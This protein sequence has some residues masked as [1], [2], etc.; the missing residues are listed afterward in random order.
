M[1]LAPGTASALDADAVAAGRDVGAT[2]A[3]DRDIGGRQLNFQRDGEGFRDAETGSHW[4]VPGRATSGPLAGRQLTAVPLRWR[5][6]AP[7][8]AVVSAMTHTTSVRSLPLQ[9]SRGA[10]RTIEGM[11]PNRSEPTATTTRGDTGSPAVNHPC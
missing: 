4:D 5:P 6:G 3:F 10:A 7:G 8:V 9:V 2:G 11:S 1:R